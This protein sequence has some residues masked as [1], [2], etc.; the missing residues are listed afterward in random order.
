MDT[1]LC[2]IKCRLHPLSFSLKTQDK[3]TCILAKSYGLFIQRK[4][5]KKYFLVVHLLYNAIDLITDRD[6]CLRVARLFLLAGNKA[7]TS[8][9]FAQAFGHLESGKLQR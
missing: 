3:F 1:D 2:M 9:A 5:L 7:L 4:S 8:T 6:E